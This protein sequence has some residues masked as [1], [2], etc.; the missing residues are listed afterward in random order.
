MNMSVLNQNLKH[1]ITYSHFKEIKT[2]TYKLKNT[3]KGSC[4]VKMLMKEIV[5]DRNKR[6]FLSTR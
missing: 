2:L 4:M 1:S 6:Q 3:C 5:E